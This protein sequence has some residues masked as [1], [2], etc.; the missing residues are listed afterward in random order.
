M[1]G[2]DV[3]EEREEDDIHDNVFLVVI[4]WGGG[5][6]SMYELGVVNGERWER[7]K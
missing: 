2:Q 1:W 6:E 5:V 4:I 3:V 7:E